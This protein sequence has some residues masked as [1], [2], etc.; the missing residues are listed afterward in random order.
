MNAALYEVLQQ[1]E[2]KREYVM[3]SLGI[4]PESFKVAA[5]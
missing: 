4:K 2:Q 3:I 5:N 1:Q